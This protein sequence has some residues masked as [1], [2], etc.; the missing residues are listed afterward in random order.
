MPDRPNCH[1][2]VHRLN[3]PGNCHSACRHPMTR[4][5]YDHPVFSLLGMAGGVPPVRIKGFEIEAYAR[6]GDKEGI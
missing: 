4:V 3:V 1:A 5:A 6:P 2:C